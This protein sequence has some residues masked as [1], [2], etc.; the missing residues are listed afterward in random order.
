VIEVRTCD[1]LSLLLDGEIA[2]ALSGELTDVPDRVHDW[3]LFEEGIVVQTSPHHPFAKLRSVP[4]AALRDEIWIHRPDCKMTGRF[5]ASH[6][7]DNRPPRV[8]HRAHHTSHLQE[9]IGAGLGIMLAPEH[10]PC[11]ASV[12]ARPIEGNAVRRSVHLFTVSGR[13]RGA[14]LESFVR[15]A[16]DHD[17]DEHVRSV[18]AINTGCIADTYDAVAARNGRSACRAT[19]GAM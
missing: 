16:R 10:M 11:S 8:S 19:R 1:L 18:S 12:V 2:A 15:V 4:A 13:R 6:F 17:W 9:M 5:W 3:P 7:A 14:P